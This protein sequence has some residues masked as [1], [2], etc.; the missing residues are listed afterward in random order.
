M[1]CRWHLFTG[2]HNHWHGLV[3][4]DFQFGLLNGRSLGHAGS[5]H[6]GGRVV[7]RQ[8]TLGLFIAWKPGDRLIVQHWQGGFERSGA[9]QRSA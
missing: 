6:P 8:E 2:L 5:H 1:V 4:F 3:C 9:S 7:L